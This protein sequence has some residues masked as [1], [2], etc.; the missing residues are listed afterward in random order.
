MSETRKCSSCRTILPEG[1]AYAN[2]QRCRDKHSEYVRIKYRENIAKGMC[3]ICGKRPRYNGTV[4]C[5]VCLANK[6]E[7]VRENRKFREKMG[8]CSRC[9]KNRVYPPE[10][11]CPECLAYTKQSN[12]KRRESE[13]I[14]RKNL[15]H[16]RRE[17]G[18]CTKCGKP[19]DDGECMCKRCRE[20]E[21]Y[22]YRK[23]WTERREKD[24]H[25]SRSERTKY[26]LCYT[27]GLPIEDDC[28]SRKLCKKCYSKNFVV[29]HGKEY[30][31]N[32]PYW[33]NDNKIVFMKRGDTS[34]EQG[35]DGSHG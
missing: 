3:G 7:E 27:C 1:Y 16:L 25:I 26:G 4:Y 6:K 21:N 35:V 28:P 15:Y 19:V 2:C 34:D 23:R 33:E 32:N 12:K 5:E 10:K 30:G 8:F 29:L 9:G 17:K 18:L 22:G 14:Y 24:G 31:G 13:K 20:V 11:W